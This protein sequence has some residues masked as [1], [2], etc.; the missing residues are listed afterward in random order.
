MLEQKW[1]EEIESD[2]ELYRKSAK[3]Q[4]EF[5]NNSSFCSKGDT[6]EVTYIPKIYSQKTKQQ[7]EEIITTT[8]AVSYTHL[9]AHET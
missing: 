5:L 7:F 2:F 1:K 4:Q 8:Y 3:K 6:L 9:R